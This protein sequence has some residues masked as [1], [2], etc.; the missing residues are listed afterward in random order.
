MIGQ[1]GSLM[2]GGLDNRALEVQR[3]QPQPGGREPAPGQLVVLQG[4]LNSHFD[5]VEEWGVDL[6]STPVRASDWF[7]RRGLMSEQ[8]RLNESDV[9]RAVSVREGLR[10]LASTNRDRGYR[11]D[12]ATLIE[13]GQAAGR[14]PLRLALAGQQLVLSP[15][16]ETALDRALGVVLVIAAQAMI[17]GHWRRLK[18]C[19]GDDCGWVFYDHSRNN[20][21]RWCSMAICGGRTKTR[22]HYHKHRRVQ[23]QRTQ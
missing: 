2:V 1:H 3:A 11:P 21:G 7:V 14:V 20:S 17:D 19:P 22:T 15:Q 5:L 12:A 23:A 6:L 18:T 9:E 16:G 10:E 8:R 13:L 4:F